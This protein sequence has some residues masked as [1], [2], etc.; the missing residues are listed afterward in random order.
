MQALDRGKI[1]KR[2]LFTLQLLERRRP[3]RIADGAQ[4][5]GPLRVAVA[6]VVLEAGG[7]SE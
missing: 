1:G 2:G 6:S 7:M 3:E 5:V 4:A